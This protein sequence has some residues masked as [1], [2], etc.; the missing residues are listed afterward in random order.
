MTFFL[1]AGGY[2]RRA[3]P[4]S[5]HLPK[6]LFPLDGVPLCRR[7][8]DQLRESGMVSGFINIHHLATS[9]AAVTADFPAVQVIYE[10]QL[11]GSAVIRKALPGLE[12]RLLVMNG[13][14]YLDLDLAK[15]A[16]KAERTN[17]DAVLLVRPASAGYNTLEIEEDR[18]GGVLLA[19]RSPWMYCGVALFSAEVVASVTDLNF[20]TVLSRSQFDVR[21]VEYSGMWL[22][23]GD[24]AAYFRANTVFRA[25]FGGE[26]ENAISEGATIAFTAR[27]R[28][29]I[30]WPSARVGSDCRID[31]CIV[32]GTVPPATRAHDAILISDRIHPLV[33]GG[34]TQEEK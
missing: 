17:A 24:Q 23:F 28:D 22:D 18:F 9:F 16:E 10:P 8:L 1:L 7:M 25:R 15:M 6:P 12:D 4:L 33:S 30:L 21:V 5:F 20:F 19:G 13:D 31:R 32:I 26:G 3:E 2:G 11:S 14:I 27:V 29:S 34:L